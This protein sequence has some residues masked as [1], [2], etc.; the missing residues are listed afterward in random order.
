MNP[1]FFQSPE[2]EQFKL[3]TGYE[4]SYRINDIL[5]LQRSLTLGRSML[6]SPMVSKAQLDRIQITDNRKGNIFIGEIKKIAQDNKAIF[7]RLELDIPKTVNC[8]L[9][10]VDF[11]KSFEEM[12]P[13]N[14]WI[15]DISKNEDEI[16]AGMKQKGRYNIR[17]AEKNNI[18]VTSSNITVEELDIFYDLYSKTGKR[19]KVAFRG[20]A[21]FENLLDILGKI[22]YARAYAAKSKVDGKEVPLAAAIVIFYA[23]EALYLY[24]GSSDEHKNLMAPYLLHWKIMLD[25]KKAGMEKYNFL[26]IA[27]TEDPNHPW[28]GITRFKKQF[29]GEQR[30]IAGSYD[31]VL[32]PIEYQMFKIAEKIRRK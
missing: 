24:G 2:W 32:K 31:L 29:G 3:K 18:A 4:K 28:A 23:E 19:K 27:P 30:D 22:D 17:V 5:V 21:Y 25:A 10:S 26:G 8:R 12:Q 9:L 7:Y 14:N 13:E 1:S 20:K 15:V 11:K 6:Y 16:L